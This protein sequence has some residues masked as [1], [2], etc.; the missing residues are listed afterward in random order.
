MYNL[1][2]HKILEDDVVPDASVILIWTKTSTATSNSNEVTAPSS[3]NEPDSAR[4]N[5]N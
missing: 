3:S 4:W 2:S 5:R 1:L